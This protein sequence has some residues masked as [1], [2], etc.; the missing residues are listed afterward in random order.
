MARIETDPNYTTPTFSRATAATDLFKKEDVQNLA[1]AMSTHDHTTGKGLTLAATSFPNRTITNNQIALDTIQYDTL[2]ANAVSQ[3]AFANGSTNNP[4]T[5]TA[6]PSWADIPELSITMTTISGS[7]ALLAWLMC[8]MSG[9]ING[10]AG[11]NLNYDGTDVLQSSALFAVANQ[12]LVLSTVYRWAT[13][14]AASHTI[15][16]RWNISSGTLTGVWNYRSLL[17]VEMRA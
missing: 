15:K 14:T 4:T 2:A 12:T 8:T 1:A 6:A 9:P 3:I 16:G 13:P 5:T 7:V 11:L 17:V 10:V